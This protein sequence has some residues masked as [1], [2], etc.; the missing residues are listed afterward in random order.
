MR[1][2][3]PWPDKTLSP[4]ARTHHQIKAK[5]TKRARVEGSLLAHGY[6]D[7]LTDKD[8]IETIRTFYPPDRR[9]RD[10]DNMGAMCKAYQ[11]GIFDALGVN[12][13]NVKQSSNL[14]GKSE[15]GGRVV[16]EIEVIGTRE[17]DCDKPEVYWDDGDL[18]CGGCEVVIE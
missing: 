5:V 9:K 2:E 6:R 14:I 7:T 13:S 4:N 12:D 3:L 17:C 15:Q 16:M 10:L 11:D 1:I 18:I 8:I